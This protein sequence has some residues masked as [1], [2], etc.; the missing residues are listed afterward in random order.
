MSLNDVLLVGPGAIGV[1]FAGRLAQ[2]GAGVTV[3]AR[4]DYDT[5]SANGYEIK[6]IAGDFNWKPPVVR[7][8][9]GYGRPARLI[10]VAVKAL[11]GV[12]LAELVRPAVGPQTAFLL[13]QNGLDVEVPLSGAFPDNELLSA[14]AFIGVSRVAPGR[15]VHSGGGTLTVGRYRAGGTSP[16]LEEVC[17]AFN[18]AGVG[19]KT[20]DDTDMMRYRKLLWNVPFNPLSVL[21]GGMNTQEMVN[22]P[23]V[24]ALAAAMMEEVRA[25]AAADGRLFTDDELKWNIDYTRNFPAYKTSMLLDFEAGR[26]LEVEA[27][28]GALVR[29]ARKN[30]V[31]T[32]HVDTAYAL[33]AAVDIKN[34]KK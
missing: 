3:A 32:P 28:L 29:R 25:V 21:T 31:A 11:P 13:I 19:C 15:V 4:S 33:L 16:V 12:D 22:D 5:V 9:A 27:I 7:G 20:A 24:V 23:K 26:Q 8:A 30:G 1:Y 17:A 6:S 18:A 34:R 10:V 2:A 14:I